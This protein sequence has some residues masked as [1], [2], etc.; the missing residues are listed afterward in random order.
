MLENMGIRLIAGF[1]VIA[2]GFMVMRYLNEGG[3]EKMLEYTRPSVESVKRAKSY[4]ILKKKKNTTSRP[5]GKKVRFAPSAVDATISEFGSWN[6]NRNSGT[7]IM[8][9]LGNVD[10]GSSGNM[11]SGPTHN[12]PNMLQSIPLLDGFEAGAGDD[13]GELF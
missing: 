5:G 12:A 11:T 7:G 4:G 10:H 9:H 6:T 1:V 2:L 8:N 13:F 3:K